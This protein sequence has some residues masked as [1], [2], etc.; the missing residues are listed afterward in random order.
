[1][2]PATDRAQALNELITTGQ[3]LQ[4]VPKIYAGGNKEVAIATLLLEFVTDTAGSSTRGNVM[5]DRV[6]TAKFMA[7][8]FGTF[9]LKYFFGSSL[10]TE[11]G[12]NAS[13]TAVRALIAQF[14][15]AEPPKKPL[16]DSQISL[17]LK[18]QGIECARRTVA[19]YREAL[20]I[21]P[22]NLRKTL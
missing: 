22:T 12:G 13:S 21:A 18:E 17:M 10:V 16:S 20:K 11:T 5:D 14:V 6:T 19:K 3:A 1:M 15:A 4:H 8:P 2:T 7:T 9:E